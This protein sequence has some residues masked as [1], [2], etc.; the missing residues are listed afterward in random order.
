MSGALGCQVSMTAEPT[1]NPL[2]HRVKATFSEPLS[3][4]NLMLV[5]NLFQQYAAKNDV[6][7]QGKMEGWGKELVM[8]V[9]LKRRLGPPKDDHPAG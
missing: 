9:A 1:V 7:P 2:V 3:G 4:K 6:I 8:N 5:W